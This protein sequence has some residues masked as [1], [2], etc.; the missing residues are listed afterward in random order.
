MTDID[1]SRVADELVRLVAAGNDNR[2]FATACG[3][4]AVIGAIA[5]MACT[6]VQRV[7]L[8]QLLLQAAQAADPDA[9]HALHPQ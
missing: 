6:D 7:A 5:E 2:A 1:V 9:L 8:A 3:L 4:I